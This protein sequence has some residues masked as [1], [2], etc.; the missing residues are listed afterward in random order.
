VAATVGVAFVAG[1]LFLA[2]GDGPSGQSAI[3][4]MAEREFRAAVAEN[5]TLIN[6]VGEE[7]MRAQAR[8][9]AENTAAFAGRFGAVAKKMAREAGESEE[10]YLK[11]A[12]LWL[13][14]PQSQTFLRL[15][16]DLS[17]S[18]IRRTIAQHLPAARALAR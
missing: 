6:D 15:N 3:N 16:V 8:Q 14:K 11:A 13:A 9:R 2:L 12:E 4:D 18:T 10:V 17:E 5:P 7:F 1:V